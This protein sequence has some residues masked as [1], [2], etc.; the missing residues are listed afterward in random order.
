MKTRLNFADGGVEDFAIL[1]IKTSLDYEEQRLARGVNH[2]E[3]YGDNA[4]ANHPM[5]ILKGHPLMSQ[6]E[7]AP[8]AS[9][10]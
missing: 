5:S 4:G 9:L 8:T 7:S 10:E 2:F 3:R 1:C 6:D